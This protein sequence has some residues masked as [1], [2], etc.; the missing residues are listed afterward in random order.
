VAV[1][2]GGGDAATGAPGAAGAVGAAPA[3]WRG[4]KRTFMNGEIIPIVA[5][6][7]SANP[8]IMSEVTM[9]RKR[10]GRR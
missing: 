6:L 2:A 1:A 5:P 8:K 4:V 9:R 3:T 10:Y 7:E